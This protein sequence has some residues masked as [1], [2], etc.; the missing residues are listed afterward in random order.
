MKPFEIFL[1]AWKTVFRKKRSYLI[2]SIAS[3]LVFSVF[4]IIPVI[5]VPG[6][7]IAYQ[8]SIMPF[9]DFVTLITLSFITGLAVVFNIYIF[10]QKKHLQ[11]S[12]IG[13]VGI[14]GI[15]ALLSSF[16]GSFSCIAC[17]ATIIGFFGL[18]AVTFA[19]KFRIYFALASVFLM[20]SSV[21]FT[22]RKVLHVC[23][24]CSI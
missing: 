21:Y 16:F 11:K 13:Q 3:F 2:F 4:I 7:D 15:A 23:D 12:Q 6:N 22:A 14:T 20:L 24:R 10:N 18:T 9:G 5:I 1:E 19:I 8:L 17:A